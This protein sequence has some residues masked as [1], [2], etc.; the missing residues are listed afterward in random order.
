LEILEK[1]FKKHTQ[2][3]Y[4]KVYYYNLL[5]KEFVGILEISAKSYELHELQCFARRASV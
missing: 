3:A 4:A 5:S 2:K 1:I